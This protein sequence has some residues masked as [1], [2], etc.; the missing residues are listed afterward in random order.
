MTTIVAV[1]EPDSWGK[2]SVLCH[3]K[4]Q[5]AAEYQVGQCDLHEEIPSSLLIFP[6]ARV[7]VELF[8]RQVR[9]SDFD[10]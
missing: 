2:V 9:S 10:Y 5:R 6:P 4:L 7:W 1:E 8:Q 3:P